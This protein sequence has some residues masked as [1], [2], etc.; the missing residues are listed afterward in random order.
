MLIRSYRWGVSDVIRHV[1]RIR[2]LF[3]FFVGLF[4][5][6]VIRVSELLLP[7]ILLLPIFSIRP[8]FSPPNTLIFF[9]IRLI[10]SV[11]APQ[12]LLPLSYLL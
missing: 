6:R 3:C 7:Y 2:I 8:R 11:L 5:R 12:V 1:T 10:V 9:A 4:P